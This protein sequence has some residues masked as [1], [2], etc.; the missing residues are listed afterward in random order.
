MSAIHVPTQ[1]SDLRGTVRV[2]LSPSSV[3]GTYVTG[4]PFPYGEGVPM[5]DGVITEVFSW[6]GMMPVNAKNG[7][8]S[9]KWRFQIP[10]PGVGD[11]ALTA[12]LIVYEPGPPLAIAIFLDSFVVNIAALAGTFF[13][14]VVLPC[15][16][17]LFRSE[18]RR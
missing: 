15:D 8:A 13:G 12:A 11:V 7:V 17:S 16:L 2:D 14:E 6:T 18:E 9:L 1:L 5:L 10:G 4:S 3:N